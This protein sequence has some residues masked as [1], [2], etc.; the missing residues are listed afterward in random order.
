LAFDLYCT[1]DKGFSR[2]VYELANWP[3]MEEGV[4][5]AL[6]YVGLCRLM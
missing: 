1:S 4:L 6:A 3:S 2:Q 5:C